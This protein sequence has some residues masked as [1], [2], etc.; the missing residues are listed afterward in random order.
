LPLGIAPERTE[1]DQ[2][3]EEVA[4]AAFV[5]SGPTRESRKIVGTFGQHREYVELHG[6]QQG[7][8]S[9]ERVCDLKDLFWRPVLDQPRVVWSE[10]G[11]CALLRRRAQDY[12]LVR[13]NHERQSILMFAN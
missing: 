8:R 10:R 5:N 11:F 6:A 7:L 13:R 12:W 3:I 9:P 1:R 4:C 2:G